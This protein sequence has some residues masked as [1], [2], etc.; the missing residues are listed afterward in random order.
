MTGTVPAMRILIP[1]LGFGRAG[2]YR[3]LSELANVWLRAGHDVAFAVPATSEVPYFPTEATIHWLDGKGA[4]AS[5][6]IGHGATGVGNLKALLGGM[7]RL[8]HDYDVVLANHSLTTWPVV[9]GGV[10][11]RKRFYYIQAYE[12]EYY[13]MERKP[14]LWLASRLSYALP[15]RQIANASI[16]RHALVRPIEIVPF[17][18]DLSVF[19]PRIPSVRQPGDPLVVGCIGRSEPQKGTGY[20]L[21]A[22]QELHAKDP[23]HRLRIAYGNLPEGW[24][25]EA[26]EIVVPRNDVELAAF[27]RSL[28]VLVAAG[29][30][31]HG[32]PHY[33]ALEALASGVALVTTGF[34]PATAD[35]AWLVPNRDS[36]AIADTLET[37]AAN[38]AEAAHRTELGLAAVVPFAWSVVADQALDTFR[39]FDGHRG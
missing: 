38:P 11:K 12:P 14:A 32:A 4:Q 26:A 31:Q 37:I 9:L 36:R 6:A 20:V 25:H 39:R 8:H 28:D 1:M 18:I 33:P 23:R 10:P 34:E 21:E 19:T 29:T 22:F 27:Y 30:V 17:G 16:Y 15:F 13:A 5:S 24:S 2:G 3:V 7:R 35:N